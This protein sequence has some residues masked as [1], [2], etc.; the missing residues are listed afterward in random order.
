MGS[1]KNMDVELGEDKPQRQRKR[2]RVKALSTML[3]L[4]N[5][6]VQTTKRGLARFKIPTS[7]AGG[8]PSPW[9][10]PHLNLSTDMGPDCVAM[11]HYMMYEGQY[12][13][14]VD[15]DLSHGVHNDV[16]KDLLKQLGLWHHMLAM[17]GAMNCA[18]GS[19]MSPPRLQQVRDTVAEY[20]QLA[21]PHTDA[22]FQHWLPFILEELG[23]GL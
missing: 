19:T 10:W 14:H 20:M 17:M 13:C 15:Y 6:L 7:A 11:A 23:I 18:Y 22:W 8:L 21:N 2:R 9:T 12:N 3:A 4:N 1:A 16:C 5:M